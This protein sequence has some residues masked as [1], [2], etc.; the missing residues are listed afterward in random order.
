MSFILNFCFSSNKR[1]TVNRRS[2]EQ[3]I[4]TDH[5]QT[6]CHVF[7]NAIFALSDWILIIHIGN[8]QNYC[9]FVRISSTI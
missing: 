8:E 1:P 5:H 4:E 9:I 3:G 2:T 6:F 7:D